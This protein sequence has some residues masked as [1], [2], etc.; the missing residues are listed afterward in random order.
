MYQ[1]D[2]KFKLSEDES[3]F[4]PLACDAR[5]V[6]GSLYGFVSCVRVLWLRTT[7]EQ[8]WALTASTSMIWYQRLYM[9]HRTS[10]LFCCDVSLRCG[11]SPLCDLKR[12][13][14]E[15]L[16]RL[17][18]APVKNTC[19]AFHL[20]GGCHRYLPSVNRCS[21]WSAFTFSPGVGMNVIVPCQLETS[22]CKHTCTHVKMT[23]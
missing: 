10:V 11:S 7:D 8:V 23:H 18:E 9:R 1:Y 15:I 4:T 16:A 19:R 14:G 3:D 6:L 17:R 2:A 21:K 12:L 20:A 5:N 22:G 13:C